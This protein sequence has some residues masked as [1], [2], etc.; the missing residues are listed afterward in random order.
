MSLYK[1]DL[2]WPSLFKCNIAKIL[3]ISFHQVVEVGED[4]Y[5]H[6]AMMKFAVWQNQW[7]RSQYEIL[8]KEG[9]V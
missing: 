9:G 3:N 5:P 6:L 4:I 1:L 8:Q 2:F 7:C